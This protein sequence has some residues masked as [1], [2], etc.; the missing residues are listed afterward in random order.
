[1][2]L[3]TR[4]R[5]FRRIRIYRV[6]VDAEHLSAIYRPPISNKQIKQEP[7]YAKHGESLRF[8]GVALSWNRGRAR[9]YSLSVPIQAVIKSQGI[10]Y[11][12]ILKE[13]PGG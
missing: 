3:L 7:R 12:A 10:T 2:E 6:L 5:C 1:M 4:K 11:L 8:R 13:F 9:N